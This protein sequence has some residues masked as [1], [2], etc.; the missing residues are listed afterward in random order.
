[1][2]KKR[3]RLE[4]AMKISTPIKLQKTSTIKNTRTPLKR[5]RRHLILEELGIKMPLINSHFKQTVKSSKN[6]LR[7]IWIRKK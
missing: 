7:M 1:M 5:R 4:M 3:N 2:E 6:M